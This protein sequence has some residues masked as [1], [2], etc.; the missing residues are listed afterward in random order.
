VS[1]TRRTPLHRRRLPAVAADA[2]ALFV[3]LEQV[4]RR[5]RNTPA[6]EAGEHELARKLGLTV[7]WWAGVSVCQDEPPPQPPGYWARDVAWP[8]V[9]AV[10][11]ALLLQAV[12]P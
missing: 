8:R 4:P 5:R 3:E 9:R 7:E 2:L 1:G 6:F 11:E 12:A 10:R